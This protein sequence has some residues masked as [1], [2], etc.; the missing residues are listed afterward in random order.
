MNNPESN[1]FN[2]LTPYT[3]ILA[4]ATLV[5][6]FVMIVPIG[7][8]HPDDFY[9]GRLFLDI[10][11]MDGEWEKWVPPSAPSFFPDGVIYGII[12]IFTV[13]ISIASYVYALI[14]STSTTI[15]LYHFFRWAALDRACSI[16][17]VML[18]F[19]GFFYF[20]EK[21]TFWSE[22]SQ[23]FLTYFNFFL[24][25]LLFVLSTKKSSLWI[26]FTLTTICGIVS[27]YL[28]IP[29][30]AT[31]LSTMLL[32]AVLQGNLTL[33]RAI[34][35]EI[36]VIVSITLGAVCYWMVV[37]NPQ[38]NPVWAS[39]ISLRNALT[40]IDPHLT[41]L[42][43]LYRHV[44]DIPFLVALAVVG[45]VYILNFNKKDNL[46]KYRLTVAL[47]IGAIIANIYTV[48]LGTPGTMYHPQYS[49]L[50]LNGEITLVAYSISFALL[51]KRYLIIPTHFAITIAAL[52]L[53]LRAESFNSR[54]LPYKI[55]AEDVDCI[56]RIAEH[57]RLKNGLS[58]F[59]NSDRFTLIS[60]GKL[61]LNTVLGNSLTTKHYVLS[62][63]WSERSADF[64]IVDENVDLNVYSTLRMHYP[65]AGE[66][67]TK[68]IGKPDQ[69]YTCNE[70]SIWLYSKNISCQP[71]KRGTHRCNILD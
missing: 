18:I 22:P 31:G 41:A 63:A 24:C 61:S 15:L 59:R 20:G 30:L 16:L 51:N 17:A 5:G 52:V 36:I 4:V 25:V 13:D 58:A 26:L 21:K 60:E 40:S 45:V 69:I 68:E 35:L 71:N 8:V 54:A 43:N 1:L 65:L 49:I 47:I 44:S 33:A 29:V 9:L 10:F 39:G 34:N 55:L 27:D 32:T 11:Y 62:K 50:V 70:F 14:I 48:G 7:R 3:A 42:R 19:L 57:H 2:Q 6:L 28:L 67:V 37:P 66:I 64:I 23:H 38:G 46:A 12:S 53:T 56:V